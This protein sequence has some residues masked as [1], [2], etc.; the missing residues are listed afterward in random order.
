MGVEVGWWVLV[1]LVLFVGGFLLVSFEVVGLGFLLVWGGCWVCFVGGVVVGWVWG[2]VVCGWFLWGF[3]WLCCWVW[4]WGW[5]VFLWWCVCLGCW[6]GFV[7]VGF[8][9]CVFGGFGCECVVWVGWYGVLGWWVLFWL[10][11]FV[12][13]VWLLLCV[14]VVGV[15]W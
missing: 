1:C 6:C 4:C 5:V 9:V 13:E 10:F 14:G 15:C 11:L 12:C 8:V 2:V 3:G 7:W